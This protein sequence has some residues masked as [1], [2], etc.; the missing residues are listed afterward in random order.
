MTQSLLQVTCCTL[1]TLLLI[2]DY[3]AEFTR[4]PIRMSDKCSAG[5][6]GGGWGDGDGF[7]AGTAGE[8][9]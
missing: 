8:C 2:P 1:A 3:P 7:T 9:Y 4:Q 6:R 5:D